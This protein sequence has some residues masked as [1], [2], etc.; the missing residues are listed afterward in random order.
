MRF[1]SGIKSIAER[2]AV[3]NMDLGL[4]IAELCAQYCNAPAVATSRPDEGNDVVVEMNHRIIDMISIAAFGH[5]EPQPKQL[6][7]D[8][9]V[10][11]VIP[12]LS[13]HDYG[14]QVRFWGTTMNCHLLFVSI[15]SQPDEIFFIGSIDKKQFSFARVGDGLAISPLNHEIVEAKAELWGILG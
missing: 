12:L 13:V 5:S 7:A 3:T 6:P 14:S 2:S 8:E 1:Q 10:Q 11:G 4:I 15:L 9:P